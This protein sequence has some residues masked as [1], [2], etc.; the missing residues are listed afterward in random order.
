MFPGLETGGKSK[1]NLVCGAAGGYESRRLPYFRIKK[2]FDVRVAVKLSLK[3]RVLKER[4]SL[5]K[6]RTN[7]PN[8][9]AIKTN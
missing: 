7:V 2:M 5:S 8:P 6:M 4:L 3:K 9:P 1:E